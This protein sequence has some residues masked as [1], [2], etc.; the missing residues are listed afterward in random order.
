MNDQTRDSPLSITDFH[1]RIAPEPVKPVGYA[2]LIDRYGLQ[3][4]LPQR[5][6]AIAERH[7]PTSTSEWQLL[8]PR[9]APEDSLFDIWNSRSS[10]RAST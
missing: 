9:H 10:G 5:L 8:S 7:K 2:A 3:L 1:G 4:P 6:T